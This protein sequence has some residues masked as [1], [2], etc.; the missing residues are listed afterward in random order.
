[1]DGTNAM[2]YL[3]SGIMRLVTEYCEAND[4]L[5]TTIERNQVSNWICDS[6]YFNDVVW[7]LIKQYLD[8][9]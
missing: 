1:M 2:E 8:E 9:L 4:I 3:R 6:E 7:D 5:I